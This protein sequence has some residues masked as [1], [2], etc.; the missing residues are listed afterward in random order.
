[1]NAVENTTKL[2][3]K[4]AHPCVTSGDYASN[5][6]HPTL[7]LRKE[8]HSAAGNPPRLSFQTAPWS[9][10]YENRSLSSPFVKGYCTLK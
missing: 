2:R 3:I 8:H 9:A 6:G 1:M 7:G 4:T 10:R 5:P